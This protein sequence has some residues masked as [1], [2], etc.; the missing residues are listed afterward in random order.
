MQIRYVD[1]H[2]HSI[3]SDGLHTPAEVVELAVRAGLA[4]LALTDHDTVDGLSEAGEAASR[5]GIQFVPGLELSVSYDGQDFH[6]LAYWIDPDNPGL[7][8]LLSEI[9]V[10]RVRRTRGILNKL[11]AQGIFLTMEEVSA[12]TRGGSVLGRPHVALA[13]MKK[14]LVPGFAEAF[15][16]FL[17]SGAP[18]YV[19]KETAAPA[20][21]LAVIRDAGGV[22]VLAH[23]GAYRMNGA[24]KI[25][26]KEGLQGLETEYPG[27]HPDEARFFRRIADRYGL[28]TS[29]GS[30]FHGSGI[31]SVP[32]G[33]VRVDAGLLVH[34]AARKEHRQ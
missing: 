12:E 29:G 6:V 33:G 27:C 26:V 3:Y 18:A 31:S 11:H 23:P 19:G 4:G 14:G 2:L 25:F 7:K 34:L 13:L 28:A 16:R 9:S 5:L 15:A 17:G 10:A 8:T 1:L 30:D 32:I 20:R 21:A 22:S 24:F